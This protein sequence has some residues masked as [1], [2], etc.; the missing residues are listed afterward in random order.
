MSPQQQ[1]QSRDDFFRILCAMALAIVA[2]VAVLPAD[3]PAAAPVQTAQG[4]A[5]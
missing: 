3:D 4:P 1:V 5:R 2:V